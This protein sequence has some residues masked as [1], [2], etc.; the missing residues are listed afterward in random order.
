M[1]CRRLSAARAVAKPPGVSDALLDPQEL[2]AIQDAIRE[3]A[4]RRGSQPDVEPTRLALI[5]DDRSV[6]Q[7]RP[8][9]ISLATRWVRKATKALRSHLPGT[10]QLDVVGAEAIDGQL[11]KDELRGAWVG[12]GAAGDA[13]VVLAVQGPVIDI[14]A[15]RR[16]GAE[17][18]TSE[19]DAHAVRRCRSGCFSPPAARCSTAWSARVAR[20]VRPASSSPSN[21]DL[22]IVAAPDRGADRR[23]R[24]R[25]RSPGSVA[26]R[27]QIYARPESLLAR[28]PRSP[29]SRR[30]RVGRRRARQRPD[31]GRRRA[32]HPAHAAQEAA[33]APARLDARSQFV[34][35][36]VPV[37]CAG[38]LKAW[39]KPV[40]CRGVLAVQIITIVHGQGTKS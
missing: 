20:G 23:A 26:G 39:G 13:E 5:A 36:R 21:A 10:W 4:P 37:Y 32:R 28:P 9:L 3:T 35:S 29:R 14:A 1:S 7:A 30:R 15:A 16:C 6:E 38:V 17:A 11:A 34:D 31:R 22:A 25:S 2:E 33:H 8:L 24:R 18:P 19:N 12:G 40:V 27:V